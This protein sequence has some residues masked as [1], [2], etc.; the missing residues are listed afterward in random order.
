MKE[1]PEDVEKAF[2]SVMITIIIAAICVVF[3]AGYADSKAKKEAR[4]SML[5]AVQNAEQM[6]YYEQKE[7][8]DELNKQRQ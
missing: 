7:Y 8:D 4:K 3:M 6:H 1:S 5:K 2:Q